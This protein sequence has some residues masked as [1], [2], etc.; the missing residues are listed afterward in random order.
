MVQES[1]IPERN[2]R[3]SATERLPPRRHV[4]I[5]PTPQHTGHV[6]R[7]SGRQIPGSFPQ[8]PY[9]VEAT[10]ANLDH[11]IRIAVRQS[12]IDQCVGNLLSLGY[13][14]SFDG[15]RGRIAVVAEAVGGRLSD[16]IEMIEEERKAYAEERRAYASS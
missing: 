14:S 11:D 10:D 7:D 5:Y 1:Q 13:G 9:D 2:L 3:R 12:E 15:G 6:E 4:T 16:A 8:E